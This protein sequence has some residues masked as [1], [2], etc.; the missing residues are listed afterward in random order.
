[1]K[2]SAQGN[3][4]YDNRDYLGTFSQPDLLITPSSLH[5]KTG[6]VFRHAGPILSLY[7]M[8]EVQMGLTFDL[9]LAIDIPL[10]SCVVEHA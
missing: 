1:M 6:T 9:F 3:L 5:I 10:T 7:K 8:L 4:D 2:T